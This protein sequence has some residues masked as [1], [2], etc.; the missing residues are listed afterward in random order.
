MNPSRWYSRCATS[1]VVLVQITSRLAPTA[2]ARSRQARTSRVAT[3]R[4]RAAGGGRY[5]HLNDVEVAKVGERL[6]VHALVQLALR[7]VDGDDSPDRDAAR[8]QGL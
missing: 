6:H 2:R 4:P 8:K 7:E 3:P 1:I 5:E